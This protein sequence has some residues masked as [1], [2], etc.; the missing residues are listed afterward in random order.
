MLQ[1]REESASS[2]QAELELELFRQAQEAQRERA[3]GRAR[4]L[5]VFAILVVLLLLLMTGCAGWFV[6]NRLS[7]SHLR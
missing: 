5:R 3:I 4:V 6:L 7:T 1:I 2:V